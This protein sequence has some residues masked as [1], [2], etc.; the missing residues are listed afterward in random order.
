VGRKGPNS[1][2]RAGEPLENRQGEGRRLAGARLRAT[3]EVP[4][5]EH[6]G[7]GARL[8]GSWPIVILF[9]QGAQKRGAEPE[10]VEV[11]ADARIDGR[12]GGL[13]QRDVG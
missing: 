3:D 9:A 10:P 12:K 11:L 13:P 7:N 4:A 5:F 8:N 6:R 1:G 2:A